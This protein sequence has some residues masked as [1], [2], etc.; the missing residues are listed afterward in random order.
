MNLQPLH[1]IAIAYITLMCL[2]LSGCNLVNEEKKLDLHVDYFVIKFTDYIIQMD[3]PFDTVGVESFSDNASHLQ[4]YFTSIDEK[5]IITRRRPDFHPSDTLRITAEGDSIR[6]HNW[7]L[8]YKFDLTKLFPF[9][10]LEEIANE[11]PLI[12][13][14]DPPMSIENIQPLD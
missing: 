1:K 6:L 13:W 4:N 9:K 2:V 7:A 8:V 14:V 5:L 11:E 12:E 10:E 3:S